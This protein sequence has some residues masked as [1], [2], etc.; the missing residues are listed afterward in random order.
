M[1]SSSQQ[2]SVAPRPNVILSAAKNLSSGLKRRRAPN[3]S[4]RARRGICFFFALVLGAIYLNG[5]P[6]PQS[7]PPIYGV[8]HV[9][10]RVTNRESSLVF[11]AK[12]LGYHLPKQC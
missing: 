10:F 9:R 11:F 3:L 6:K 7:R 1:F 2:P 5:A 4:S 12:G 8:A